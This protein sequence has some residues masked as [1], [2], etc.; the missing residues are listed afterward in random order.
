L[1]SKGGY[2][3]VPILLGSIVAIAVMVERYIVIRRARKGTERVALQVLALLKEGH[4]EA[5]ISRC[6]TRGT[7]VGQVLLAGLEAGAEH[8]GA[9]EIMALAGQVELDQLEKRMGWV[10]M[11][12]VAAPLVGFLGTVTGMIR[13]FMQV[14]SHAGQVDSSV[15]AGGIWEALV[16]TAGGLAVGILA[17]VGHNWLVGHIEGLTHQLRKASMDLLR[18]V[19]VGTEED[20]DV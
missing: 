14:Q 11:V 19:S 6:K 10:S 9:K 5:A 7:P 1:V 18:L 17:L 3:M 8:G 4:K 2:F 15:L 20:V 13:A 12:A 16:T